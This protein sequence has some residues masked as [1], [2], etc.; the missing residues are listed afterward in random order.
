M[1]PAA[2]SEV[3]KPRA[4]GPSPRPGPWKGVKRGC[5]DALQSC[6]AATGLAS[7]YVRL[8]K[9]TG[10]TIFNYHS[11]ADRDHARW[12]DPRYHMTPKEFERQVKFFA[13]R[14]S[15]VSLGRLV[16]ALEEGRD[17]P[18]RSVVVTLDDGYRDHLTVAAPIL[19]KH[20]IPATFFLPT[21]YVERAENQC[22]DRKSVV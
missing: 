19:A 18:P 22:L 5:L 11:V 3:I 15:P 14:R 1:G 10:A 20:R 17:L 7:L 4:A 21:G 8:R 9:V 13:T 6:L 16:Q 12:V 2:S